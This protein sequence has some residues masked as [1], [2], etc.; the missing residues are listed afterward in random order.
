MPF[1][2]FRKNNPNKRLRTVKGMGEA[3][4]VVSFLCL[5]KYYIVFRHVFHI[6][7]T[8]TT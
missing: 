6:S 8:F 4:A 5:I 7:H 3:D 2:S 1:F